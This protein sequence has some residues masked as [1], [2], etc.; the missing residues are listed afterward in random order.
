L[1]ELVILVPLVEEGVA[2]YPLIL[3]EL[4]NEANITN[5]TN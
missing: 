1:V 3:V 2:L 5:V 4:I